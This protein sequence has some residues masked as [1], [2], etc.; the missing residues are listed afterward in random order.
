MDQHHFN[1]GG[2]GSS[3]DT[4]T[5][6]AL[7]KA[8]IYILE[9]EQMVK[10]ELAM[11]EKFYVADH[12]DVPFE[13]AINKAKRKF[14]K[15]RGPT[16][17]KPLNKKKNRV[18][19]GEME[20]DPVAQLWKG[21]DSD[22]NNFPR[23]GAPALITNMGRNEE[24]VIGNMKWDPKQKEWRGNE[25]DLSKFR[26]LKPGLITQLNANF[27]IRVENGMV[28]DP[29]SMK[30]RGNE[31]D[32]DVFDAMDDQNNDNTFK[33]EGEFTLSKKLLE[34][35]RESQKLHSNL[36]GWFP[37]E[38]DLDDRDHFHSIRQMSIMKLVKNTSRQYYQQQAAGGSG[39]ISIASAVLPSVLQRKAVVDETN[40]WD[41]VDFV[42][43]QPSLKLN[44]KVHQDANDEDD[45]A[46]QWDKEMG[47]TSEDDFTASDH[48][49]RVQT[50]RSN[51]NNNSN[52][53][54]GSSS[55]NN[56][57]GIFNNSISNNNNSGS[58]GKQVEEWNDFGSF[59]ADKLSKYKESKDDLSDED[60]DFGSLNKS[61]KKGGSTMKTILA[62]GGS[63][64]K[65]LS[66]LNANTQSMRRGGTLNNI[67]P[68]PTT[69][70]T[71]AGVAVG[72]N[73][74]TPLSASSSTTPNSI[75]EYDDM[76]VKGPL[77]LKQKMHSDNFS[78]LEQE[79]ALSTSK[80]ST[81]T[82]FAN[83][84]EERDIIEE[85]WPDVHIPM[86]LGAKRPND[87]SRKSPPVGKLGAVEDYGDELSINTNAP[88]VLKKHLLEDNPFG[89][90][91]D[92][93]WNDVSFPDNFK[94]SPLQAPI[95]HSTPST[96]LTPLANYNLDNSFTP[97]S[98]ASLQQVFQPPTSNSPITPFKFVK[99]SNTNI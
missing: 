71:S 67:P 99:R 28:L 72:S 56:L 48:G 63:I 46:S 92:D 51:N 9:I 1:N 22:L 73:N 8:S 5:T 96:P 97:L 20:F 64:T 26:T 58:G 61:I 59:N 90:E 12:Q 80:R 65:T 76:E 68:L 15:R 39:A 95:A 98:P 31:D 66:N 69:S 6:E 30:W 34:S 75:E 79:S 88:L 23:A 77:S 53:S 44:L 86:D 4:D 49:S 19:V 91:S 29:V 36:K 7:K 2:G 57:S 40:D 50:P 54:G 60:L 62:S 18:V 35:L 74:S 78:I 82:S 47:F 17:I 32:L 38:R 21:N 94:A 84:L 41:D 3:A 25:S 42:E 87:H 11:L 93:D 81:P 14:E 43:E 55:S 83:H 45:D 24:K 16:L 85:E 89:D 27:G 70:T 52:N 13:K 37:E 10:D 33:E